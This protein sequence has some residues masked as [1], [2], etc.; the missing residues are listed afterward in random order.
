[1]HIVLQLVSFDIVTL[2]DKFE[3]SIGIIEQKFEN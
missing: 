1:M 3:I 2:Y